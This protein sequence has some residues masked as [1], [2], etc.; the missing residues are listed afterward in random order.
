[1]LKAL[2]IAAAMIAPTAAL[3]DDWTNRGQVVLTAEQ[4]GEKVEIFDEALHGI[5]A[6]EEVISLAHHLEETVAEFVVLA[7]TG[8]RAAVREEL[9]HLNEDIDLIQRRLGRADMPRNADVRTKWFD[10]RDA[11][12]RLNRQ[13]RWFQ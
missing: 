1:M 6:P 12:S 10:L 5:N 3:A 7:K 11:A 4:L 2:M 8:T 13:F 9:D